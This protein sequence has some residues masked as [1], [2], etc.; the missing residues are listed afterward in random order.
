MVCT[1]YFFILTRA[2][3][4]ISIH[5]H[6][7]MYIS[8]AV[9]HLH[10]SFDM[11]HSVLC[12]I[13][14]RSPPRRASS[15]FDPSATNHMQAYT[16]WASDTKEAVHPTQSS[17]SRRSTAAGLDSKDASADP[18]HIFNMDKLN[19]CNRDDSDVLKKRADGPANS[20]TPSSFQSSSNAG[21]H[22]YHLASPSRGLSSSTTSASVLHGSEY[23]MHGNASIEPESSQ[24]GYSADVQSSKHV[25][26]HSTECNSTADVGQPGVFPRQGI[27]SL[28]PV[29]Y[30]ISLPAQVPA[31]TSSSMINQDHKHSSDIRAAAGTAQQDS[32]FPVNAASQH[33]VPD[34]QH[35]RDGE[36]DT[37]LDPAARTAQHVNDDESLLDSNAEVP[38][39][40]AE[41]TVATRVSNA[42]GLS[43]S[44]GLA[45]LFHASAPELSRMHRCLGKR[46]G[47]I[48]WLL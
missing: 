22:T 23:G 21:A 5:T 10:V 13:T 6:A 33:D 15:S 44:K 2:A 41:G 14:Q 25:G 17:S 47:T 45:S 19:S 26:S 39:R 1:S 48:V 34:A 31:R 32:S 8:C 18:G 36:A 4:P 37:L 24:H 46:N 40:P 9:M 16:E 20:S 28:E 12:S 27:K 29:V 11:P 38:S 43:A 35:A 42:G 7:C 3:G 30:N